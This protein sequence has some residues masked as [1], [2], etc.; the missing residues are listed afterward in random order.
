MRDRVVA[1]RRDLASYPWAAII[2]GGWNHGWEEGGAEAGRAQDNQQTA[3][4]EPG[5]DPERHP[6]GPQTD[7]SGPR[8]ADR[9]PHRMDAGDAGG[10]ARSS[11]NACTETSLPLPRE[12]GR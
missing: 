11:R 8:Q 3:T 6:L 5:R 1:R 2:L 12:E 9:Q 10:A 4:S 7:G